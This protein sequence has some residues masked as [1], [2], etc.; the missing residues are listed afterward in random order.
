[1]NEILLNLGLILVFVLIGGY[2]SA[3][4][5]AL[6]SLRESQVT[7]MAARGRR[8]ARVAKLRADSNRFLAAVQV[9]VTLA[10]FF[11]PPTAAPR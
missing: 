3:S 8:G 4:E 7:R 5:L 11:P 9:G 6:V 2:F 1:M 10:G